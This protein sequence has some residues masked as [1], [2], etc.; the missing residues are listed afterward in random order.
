ML[1][2]KFLHKIFSNLFFFVRYKSKFF[3]RVA[4][5]LEQGAHNAF[6]ESSILSFP[7]R[8]TNN[9]KRSAQIINDRSEYYNGSALGVGAFSLKEKN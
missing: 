7:T 9:K 5:W 8:I 6:V 2:Q 4:Q 1:E 3:G